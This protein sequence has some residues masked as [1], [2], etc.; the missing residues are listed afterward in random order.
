MCCGL[1][2]GLTPSSLLRDFTFSTMLR[3]EKALEDYLFDINASLKLMKRDLDEES[4]KLA[5]AHAQLT[6]VGRKHNQASNC[7]NERLHLLDV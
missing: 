1:V 7:F 5:L 4:R 6:A 2:G 3:R